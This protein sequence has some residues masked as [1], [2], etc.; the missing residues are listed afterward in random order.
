M[1]DS[2][3][4]RLPLEVW[5]LVFSCVEFKDL[6]RLA[7]TSRVFWCAIAPLLWRNVS[8]GV[9]IFFAVMKDKRS[10]MVRTG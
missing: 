4:A 3:A 5:G 2:P 10:E 6:R 1:T 9:H 8:G 7:T